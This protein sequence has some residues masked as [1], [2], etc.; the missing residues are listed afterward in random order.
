MPEIVLVRQED[1]EITD[2]ERDAARKVMF[3]FVDGLG[4]RGRKQ[5]RRLWSNLLRLEPGEMME[6]RTKQPRV[7]V[8]H[9]KHMLLE[10]RVFEAQERFENFEKGFRDWLKVGAG[11]CDWYPGPKGGVF[12]VPR[13]ISYDSL[14]QGAME[15]F[16]DNAVAFL[17]TEHA[18]K[19][20]WP[21][22]SVA[23]RIEMI[24]TILGG[25]GE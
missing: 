20:L 6:I 25:L 9:R 23:Q 16:H 4:E 19:T 3:G 15:E 14:E 10:T 12:P 17:R 1:V 2:A 8:Y 22:L 7:G 5:W 21:G 13:S 24:E 18:C 11:H